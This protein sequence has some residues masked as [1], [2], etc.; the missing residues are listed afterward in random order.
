MVAL[1]RNK[2]QRYFELITSYPKASLW[3]CLIVTVVLS[4]II[5]WQNSVDWEVAFL[6]ALASSINLLTIKVFVLT[7]IRDGN[8][9][10]KDVS[11]FYFLVFM[12]VVLELLTLPLMIPFLRAAHRTNAIHIMLG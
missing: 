4:S 7:L 8:P 3:V 9:V 5:F 12:G 11:W 2:F 6:A 1:V 10:N